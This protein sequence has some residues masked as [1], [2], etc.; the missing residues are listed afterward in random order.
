MDMSVLIT[1]MFV[2]VP[3][4]VLVGFYLWLITIPVQGQEVNDVD[5]LLFYSIAW[6]VELYR[7][8]KHLKDEEY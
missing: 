5:D 4:Y 8:Y 2:V 7:M 1:F 6:P 3:I